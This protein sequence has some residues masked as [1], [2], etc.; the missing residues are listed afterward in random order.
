MADQPKL[1]ISGN[2]DDA[3]KA[4]ATLERRFDSLE[5]RMKRTTESQKK[6][7][8]D[9]TAAIDKTTTAL[10]RQFATYEI[11]KKVIEGMTAAARKF[12]A[13]N[14]KLADQQSTFA[15]KF[16][17]SAMKLGVQ[18]NLTPAEIAKMT[19]TIGAQLKMIPVTGDISE[20][21]NLQTSLA[22]TGVPRAE[23]DSGIALRSV[24][25]LKAGTAAA[26][27]DF[28]NERE[29][30]GAISQTLK[31]YGL[32]VNAKNIEMVGGMVAE[33]YSASDLQ[34]KDLSALAPRVANLK[35]FGLNLQTQAAAFS[36]A[37]DVMGPDIAS[38]SL[39][40]FVTRLGAAGATEE[41]VK[42]LASIGLNPADVALGSGPGKDLFS[43]SAMLQKKM[44]GLSVE[45]RNVWTEKM[46]GQEGS[47]FASLMLSQEG[48]GTIRGRF[49]DLNQLEKYEASVGKFVGSRFAQSN[50]LKASSETS[51]AGILSHTPM[52]WEE[53]DL[54]QTN[55]RDQI[56][57]RAI[58]EGTP[59][60]M[61]N[62]WSSV[63][64]V[65]NSVVE[66]GAKA[67]GATP[68]GMGWDKEALRIQEQQ[69]RA[70]Q[71]IEQKMDAR[72]INRNGQA[73]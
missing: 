17:E 34:M 64:K 9:A 1:V 6:N 38:T 42:A 23:L 35:R 3:Q 29:A 63:D 26:G 48:F 11:G 16:N 50:R 13:E 30:V 55:F 45:D 36:A 66:T 40:A 67:V 53:Y 5:Q 59:A 72:P 25:K 62:S 31:G 69:L 32:D 27:K 44:G 12:G 58:Q 57:L 46:F 20:A 60:W 33:M 21:M 7:S 56:R 70:L 39:D 15:G 51:Q 52:S 22:G 8:A 73:E 37:R 24:L 61:A 43:V 41:R 71:G 28:G 2:S 14:I 49:D 19:A 4:L 47:K 18:G 54:S 68:S 10:A 65:F